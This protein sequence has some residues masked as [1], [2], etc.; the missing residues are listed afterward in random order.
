[1]DLLNQTKESILQ[2]ISSIKGDDMDASLAILTDSQKSVEFAKD[3]EKLT[4]YLN[5][6]VKALTDLIREKNK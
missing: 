5:M 4:T 1:M 3:L 6:Y 2:A